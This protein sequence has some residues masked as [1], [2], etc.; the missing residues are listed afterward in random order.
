V[1]VDIIQAITEH[2]QQTLSWIVLPKI[3]QCVVLVASWSCYD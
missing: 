3:G 2:V 1:D